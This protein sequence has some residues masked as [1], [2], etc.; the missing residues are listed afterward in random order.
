MKG[1]VY[2][3]DIQQALQEHK[4]RVLEAGYTEEQILGIF[5]YGSQ[6]YG[7]ALETSDVDTK[8]VL[9]PTLAEVMFNKI[10]IKELKL[11]NDEH[12]EVMDICHL[13][14]NLKK[15]NINFVEILFTEYKWINPKYQYLWNV[16]FEKIREEISHYD[17]N[18]CLQSICGQAI[19][20]LKQNPL[21]GKKCSNGRRLQYFLT[22]YLNGDEY[23]TCIKP[24]QKVIDE[25]LSIKTSTL[26]DD[27][28]AKELIA[29]FEQIRTL[30][31]AHPR[32]EE[33]GP[34]L[35]PEKIN[36]WMETGARKMVEKRSGLKTDF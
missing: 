15:Q 9:I 29:W 31:V 12:C 22:H 19:R 34:E 8:C 7:T 26:E 2:M 32:I 35:D 20:T 1:S 25:I 13:I 14:Y 28:Y 11:Y 3:R 16:F 4:Q 17:M 33:D 5:L 21:N 23:E 36:R 27:T 24:N 10:Q 30:E 18:K 6:N